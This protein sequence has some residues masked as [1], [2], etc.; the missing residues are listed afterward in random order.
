[1]Q[2]K[3]ETSSS[4]EAV[5]LWRGRTEGVAYWLQLRGKVEQRLG[6]QGSQG[7]EESVAKGTGKQ[8]EQKLL[9]HPRA[10]M[11]VH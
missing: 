9:P 3:S 10:D 6:K 2:I 11:L 4:R 7:T 1:M 8:E 5:E